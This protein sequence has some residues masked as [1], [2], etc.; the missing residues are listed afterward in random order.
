MSIIVPE[1]FRMRFGGNWFLSVPTLVAYKDV[2]LFA[3]DRRNS[4]G[5]LRIDFDIYDKDRNKVATIRRNQIVEEH[6]KED[7]EVIRELNRFAVVER[8]TGMVLCDIQQRNRSKAA[9]LDVTAT[10]YLP[11]GEL[12]TATLD[13]T[14]VTGAKIANLYMRDNEF[15]DPIAISIGGTKGGASI[16]I[17]L[18]E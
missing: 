7:Y 10:T 13:D 8:S 4:D 1:H 14:K 12:L 18:R 11:G 6:G 3:V 9:E 16:N 15:G 2:P 5:L 17:A